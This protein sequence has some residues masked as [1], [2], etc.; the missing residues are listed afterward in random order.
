MTPEAPDPV[1]VREV[2][3]LDGPNLYFPRPAVK[4]SLALPG[5]LALDRRTAVRVAEHAGLR[6]PRPGKPGTAQRQRFLMRFAAHVTRRVVAGFGP[7]RLTVR[8]GTGATVNDIVVAVPWRHRTWG[9]L[10]GEAV[11]PVLAALL[12]ATDTTDADRVLREAAEAISAHE[13]GGPS[14]VGVPSV[15]VVSITGTNGK[16]TTTRLVAHIAMTAGRRTAWSSTSGVVVMGGTVDAGDFSGPAGAREVLATPGLELAVLETARGGMLLRGMGVATNDVSVVTNV[17]AD[18]LGLQGIDTLDQLAE[19]KAIVTTVTKPAGWVVLNGEDPRVWAMRHTIR[20][21]PWAFSLDPDAPALRE[22]LAAGGRGITVLDG[23]IVVLRPGSDPDRLVRIVDV[24]VTLSGLSRY[25]TANALAA[26]AAALGLDLPRDAV[27]EG[28]RTFAPDPVLNEGR[29]NTYSLPLPEGGRATVILD[30]AHNEAGL[31]ALL[32]VAH[33][34]T[35][36]GARVHVGIGGTGD[37]PDDALEGMGEIAGKGSDHVVIAHKPKY[38]RGRSMEDMDAHLRTGLSRVGVAEVESYPTEMEGLL[39]LVPTLL[40]GDVVA[41]MCHDQQDELR[42]WLAEQ[43]ATAD[44]ARAVRRKVVAAR[45]EHELE[46]ELADLW[47]LADPAERREALGRLAAEHPDD[48][49]IAY[50]NARAVDEGADPTAALPGYEHALAGGLREPH[51]HRAQIQAAAVLRGTGQ[52]DRALRLLDEV[53]VTHP[54]HA[55]VAAFRALVLVDAGRADEA[56]ADL[57]DTVVDHAADDDTA[58]FRPALHRYAAE[59][60]RRAGEGDRL[61]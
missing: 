7:R 2:R 27:V 20:A 45:G 56:V 50:E 32:E 1:Q 11:G 29:L 19:V 57:V 31:E 39:A 24:P 43:G 33:G 5:Y 54:G 14:P 9:R 48:P 16:T 61:H 60:R 58:A 41:F 55:A 8:T 25:N 38:L 13:P 35:A 6:S 26:A 53:A 36:P 52:H 37:R 47:A 49:R 10:T 59:L 30:M 4:V 34:L 3:V 46:P 12:D 42:C 28:L 22:S 21:R 40:D 23:E 18:H 17:T 51:R 44:D 15:P